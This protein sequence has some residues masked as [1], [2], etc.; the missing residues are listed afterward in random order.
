MDARRS[1][2]RVALNVCG[3][4]KQAPRGTPVSQAEGARDIEATPASG[5]GCGQVAA[6]T[7]T[8]GVGSASLSVCGS[9]LTGRGSNSLAGCPPLGS[10]HV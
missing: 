6:A 7:G 8:G 9:E 5:S 10:I 1:P 4:M 3:E 2:R